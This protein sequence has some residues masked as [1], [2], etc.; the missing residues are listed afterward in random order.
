MGC[1]AD[2]PA[3]FFRDRSSIAHHLPIEE[4]AELQLAA[5]RQRFGELRSEI[6]PLE[7]LADA[8]GVDEIRKIEDVAPVLF[9][10]GFYKSFPQ[11]LIH[12]RDFDA[13]GAWLSRLSVNDLS[14]LAGR[15]FESIDGWMDALDNE[16]ELEI[17]HSSGTTGAL[18]LYPR[19]KRERALQAGM[20]HMVV[21]EWLDPIDLSRRKADHAT[22]YAV[23]WP[24]YPGGRSAILKGAGMF[25]DAVA[26]EPAMFHALLPAPMSSDW[27]IYVLEAEQARARGAPPPAPS[28][29]VRRKMDEAEEIQRTYDDRLHH[30][31]DTIRFGLAATRVVIAGGPGNLHRLA[32]E[33]LARGM[34][35]AFAPGSIVRTF[36]GLKG[37]PEPEGMEA[38]IKRFAGVDRIGAAYGMTEV[39]SPFNACVEGNFHVPPWV[40][41]MV[42]DPASGAPMPREGVRKGRAAFMDLLPR[43]YWGG[44][45]SADIVE[46]DWGRCACG[47]TTPHV[48]PAIVRSPATGADE[49]GVGAASADAIHAALHALTWD[50]G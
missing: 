50:I 38:T 24:S 16:T 47:R 32:A 28:E 37:F 39:I 12:T 27:Q 17:T 7:A 35:P 26:S 11:H 41:P 21:A 4:Q 23:V 18:S 30:L 1:F 40:V 31:L 19:G 45:V 34:E 36:G 6:P 22:D 20:Y 49:Y 10:H 15:S 2:D 44:V 14:A 33:G 42:L 43:S 9:P 3:D 48:R 29:Y 8:M 25:R 13:L 5:V 46:M